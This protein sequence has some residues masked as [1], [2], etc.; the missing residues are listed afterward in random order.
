M[1]LAKTYHASDT[2]QDLDNATHIASLQPQKLSESRYF[3]NC[4]IIVLEENRISF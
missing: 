2:M 1:T 3:T 4:S